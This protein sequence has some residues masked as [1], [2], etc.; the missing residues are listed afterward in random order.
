MCY[1][2]F[3]ARAQVCGSR[4]AGQ[5]GSSKCGS[6][7]T[8]CSVGRSAAKA[9]LLL[10]QQRV[11]HILWLPRSKGTALFCKIQLVNLECLPGKAKPLA[12]AAT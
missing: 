2:W 6:H 9:A 11:L 4:S 10:G 7:C 3:E 1:H 5:Y 8:E 12:F